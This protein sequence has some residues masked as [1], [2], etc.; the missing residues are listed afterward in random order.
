M[1]KL[2]FASLLSV[3]AILAAQAPAA[4]APAANSKT[5]TSKVKTH[6]THHSKKTTAVNS[7]S[8]KPAAK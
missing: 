8:V 2:I 6:K 4:Q 7:N 1:N 3:G 5:T